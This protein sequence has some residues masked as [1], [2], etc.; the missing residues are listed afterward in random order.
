MKGL[1]AIRIDI[2]VIAV[3]A[4]SV[5]GVFAVG[6]TMAPGAVDGGRPA[7]TAD[8]LDAPGRSVAVIDG[9][10]LEIDGARVRLAHVDAPALNQLCERDG[11]LTTCGRDAALALR[12]VIG[13]ADRKPDCVAVAGTASSTC[14][15]GDADFAEVLLASGLAMARADAPFHYRAAERRARAVPLGIWQTHFVTPAEWRAGKRLAA[16][17]TAAQAMTSATDWPRRVAGLA[18]L[19]EPIAHRALG[20][21]LARQ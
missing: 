3:A 7:V 18:I 5:A 2:A 19:P 6:T 8:R 10:T 9:D 11:R 1:K 4:V 13:L 17:A 21:P 14:R 15:V 20:L 16:E 12:K